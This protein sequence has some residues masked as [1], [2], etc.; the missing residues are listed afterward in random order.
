MRA[1]GLP[2]RARAARSFFRAAAGILTLRASDDPVLAVA[3]PSLNRLLPENAVPV[4]RRLAQGREQG[5][6]T[7]TTELWP[8]VWVVRA[9]TAGFWLGRP[10]AVAAANNGH[11]SSSLRRLSLSRS[12]SHASPGASWSALA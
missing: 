3:S 2:P 11:E 12:P 7:L 6:L 8:I 10:S 5:A 4:A 1:D 9:L